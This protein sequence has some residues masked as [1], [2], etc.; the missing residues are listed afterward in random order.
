MTE[1][2]RERPNISPYRDRRAAPGMPWPEAR[3][4]ARGAA[5]TLPARRLPLAQAAGR[6]LAQDLVALADLPVA[7]VSAMDGWAVAGS[8]PWRVVGSIHDGSS[9]VRGLVAGECAEIATGLPVPHGTEGVLPVELSHVDAGTVTSLDPWWWSPMVHVRRVG[10]E[11]V[12][13][14]RLVPYGRVATPPVLGVAA[15]AGHDAL[16]VRPPATVDVLVMGDELTTWGLPAPGRTRDALGPQL[17][18]WVQAWGAVSRHQRH[19]RD[20]LDEVVSAIRASRADVVLTTGGT[21]VGRRDYLHAAIAELGGRLDV[22]GVHVK[23]GHPMLLAELPKGRWLA[24]LP[25]NPLAACVALLTLVQPLLETL[26][27]VGPASATSRLL[28]LDQPARRG[29]GHR[30]LP[31]RVDDVRAHVLDSCGAAMLRGLAAADGMLVVSP[32]G[33]LAG[34]AL[35]YL[36]LP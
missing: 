3:A 5:T 18:S 13:G 19:V 20:R 8:P 14:D 15:A 4:L 1:R 21:S 9:P 33:A 32:R 35:D 25:G 27:G 2:S 16:L 26:H 6:V 29:D 30:L 17:P 36:P 22:D 7:D 34:D 11:A 31:V 23:P 28:D 12:R 24:G 10:E